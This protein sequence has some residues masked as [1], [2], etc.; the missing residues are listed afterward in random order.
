[1]ACT[2]RSRQ[3]LSIRYSARTTEAATIGQVIHRRG[4]WRNLEAVEY[5]TPEWVAWFN[6]R[7]LLET[8]STIPPAEREATYHHSSTRLRM[9]TRLEP[10]LPEKPGRFTTR[11]GPPNRSTVAGRMVAGRMVADRRQ[12][13]EK[14]RQCVA[15]E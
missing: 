11:F 7:R 12:W 8:I 9:A 1:V 14:A 4:P 6:H 13:C 15:C 2:G 10:E 3:Y 5:A